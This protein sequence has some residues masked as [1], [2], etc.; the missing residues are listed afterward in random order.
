M[1]CYPDLRSSR[2]IAFVGG[3]VET[4]VR[5]EHGRHIVHVPIARE[6]TIAEDRQRLGVPQIAV[7][8]GRRDEPGQSDESNEDIH[9]SPSTTR[10]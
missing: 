7:V 6:Y 3:L 2:T 5:V 1:L 9:L 4:Q 8:G 10:Q